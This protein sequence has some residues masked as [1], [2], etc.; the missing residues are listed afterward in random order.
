MI[1]FGIASLAGFQTC[2][3]FNANPT[4]FNVGV[5]KLRQAEFVSD[6]EFQYRTEATT[7][8]Q[9][10]AV[11][12]EVAEGDFDIF[13]VKPADGLGTGFNYES[14]FGEMVLRLAALLRG[15]PDEP[16]DLPPVAIP[17]SIVEPI[18]P[19]LRQL[20]RK[21]NDL[22]IRARDGVWAELAL[23]ERL[24]GSPGRFL[25]PSGTIFRL[26]MNGTHFYG[27]DAARFEIISQSKASFG[28]DFEPNVPW[29]LVTNGD[30]DL[31]A[32]GNSIDVPSVYAEPANW[33]V[34][35]IVGRAGG[36]LSIDAEYATA[37]ASQRLPNQGR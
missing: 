23:S 10:D 6:V 3:L 13:G 31:S 37:Q 9:L 19:A 7:W 18:S 22:S 35:V 5:T 28:L 25:L 17:G 29:L 27:N 15:D 21:G 4:Q 2:L 20:V 33:E 1:V 36:T 12:I 30:V 24:G 34:L 14:D 32:D 26:Q 11:K 8:L 16:D